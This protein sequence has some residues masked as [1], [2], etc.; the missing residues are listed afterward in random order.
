MKL[1]TVEN[2]EGPSYGG[3]I[4]AAVGNGE[5]KTV[6]EASLAVTKTGAVTEP[7]KALIEKY[8]EKYAKYTEIYPAVKNLYH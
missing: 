3:A 5:F 1:V 6:A 7:D 2:D 8:N 4:L